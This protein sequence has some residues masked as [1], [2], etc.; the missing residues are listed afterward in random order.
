[1]A[2][3]AG[4]C[5]PGI[6]TMTRRTLLA[7]LA[8]LAFI[9]LGLPDG[10]LGVAWP[11]IRGTYDVPLDTLGLLVAFV[12]AGYLSSSFVAG[13][14]MRRLPL[15]TI[16]WASAGTAG[17]SLVGFAI[18][19]AW[20]VMLVLG[21]VAGLSGG[22]VDAALNAYG[23]RYFDNRTLNWLHAFWGLG[24]T[25]GPMI[26][27]GVLNAGL[28]W[29]WSYAIAGTA[30]LSF[31]AV[32]FAT[33][34][35]WL[36]LGDEAPPSEVSAPTLNTLGRPVVWLGMLTFFVYG[37]LEIAVA[38][39]SFSLL[40]LGRGVPETSAG[41]FLTLYWGSLMSG[42]ILFGM[43]ADHVS[44]PLA[45]RIGILGAVAGAIL[46]WLDPS[47]SLSVAGLM[48]IG[49]GCA[50]VYASLISLTPGR[51]GARHTDSAIGFQIAAAGLGGAVVTAGVG[52]AARAFGLGAIGVCFVIATLGLL[53]LVEILVRRPPG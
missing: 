30:Q 21:F 31:A 16:L 1:M 36:T 5:D 19:P 37:G 49:F 25:I 17:L 32:L 20:P 40:T 7:L 42:R 48:L 35:R 6:R 2:K 39:W 34:D 12:V 38:H 33:R 28:V 22:A 43:V 29:R 3:D 47:R 41:I 13:A 44:L 4:P 51:V 45:V 46:F 15:G 50:P 14:I 10:L 11:S 18:S 27:T 9:S 52:I 53:V 24:T 26:V 8:Y 23:A